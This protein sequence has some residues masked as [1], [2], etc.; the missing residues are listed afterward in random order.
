M[1][2][3]FL[4]RAFIKYGIMLG[5]TGLFGGLTLTVQLLLVSSELAKVLWCVLVFIA[6]WVSRSVY[7]E[8][9]DIMLANMGRVELTAMASAIE[10]NL[11]L[12]DKEQKK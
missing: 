3:I 10:H 5:I 4:R 1:N 7:S 8:N 12:L 6:G 2:N 11:Q 9:K